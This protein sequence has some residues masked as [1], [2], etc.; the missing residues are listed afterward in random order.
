MANRLKMVEKELL[1]ILFSKK[2]SIPK[3]N[4]ALDIHR[5]TISRYY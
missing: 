1:F 5:A 2:W 4:K 3:I